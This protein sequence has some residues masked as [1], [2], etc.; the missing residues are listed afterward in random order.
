[1]PRLLDSLRIAQGDRSFGKR[2]AQLARIDAPI[3]DDWGLTPL[4]PSARTYWK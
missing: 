4:D 3:L 1:V 2:L